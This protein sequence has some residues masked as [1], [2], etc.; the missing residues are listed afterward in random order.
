M[1]AMLQAEN[2]QLIERVSN[3]R[4][5]WWAMGNHRPYR[6]LTNTLKLQRHCRRREDFIFA[7][8]GSS[9]SCQA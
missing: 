4:K 7:G 3:L 6:E 5:S 9:S 2:Q 1:V 8:D